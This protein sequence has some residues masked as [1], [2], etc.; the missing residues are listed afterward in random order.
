[1]RR[2]VLKAILF[3]FTGFLIL[4]IYGYF[5]MN[6]DSLSGHLK[7]YRLFKV[8]EKSKKK[9]TSQPGVV[10][11][12]DSVGRQLFPESIPNSL[13]S[14]ASV[15]A[16]GNYILAYNAIEANKRLKYIVFVAMPRSIGH[17]FERTT[18]YHAFMKPFY[19]FEN[20]KHISESL[21]GKINR[22]KWSHFVLFP[23]IK[24]APC[25][26]DI[27]FSRGARKPP[28]I[29]SDIAVEYLKKLYELCK[30]HKITLILVSPPVSVYYE[31]ETENW[32]RMK[33]QISLNKMGPIFNGY[34]ESIIYLDESYFKS[35]HVHFKRGYLK[36]KRRGIV[37]KMLPGYV[38]FDDT[39]H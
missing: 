2:F 21:Y 12:G 35:D 39:L 28:D 19:R 29:L 36:K 33:K 32:T 11:L 24:M 18:T 34:F 8:V 3:C 25:F 27:S 16:V 4:N 15:L 5:R 14:N 23:L 13:A 6:S 22:K 37:K 20:L 38:P 26:S 7:G 17:R 1:M 31:K 30:E 9:I 10:F